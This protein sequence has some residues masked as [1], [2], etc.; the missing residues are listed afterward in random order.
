MVDADQHDKREHKVIPG[1][2]NPASLSASPKPSSAT[3]LITGS[4]KAVE[5]FSV[6]SCVAKV[7]IGTNRTPISLNR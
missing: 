2:A 5:A 3:A 4:G 7:A 6:G 1:P